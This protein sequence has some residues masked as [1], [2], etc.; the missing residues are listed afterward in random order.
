MLER[1]EVS[2]MWCR[3][4][5]AMELRLKR[6]C[7]SCQG[8]RAARMSWKSNPGGKVQTTSLSHL[9]ETSGDCAAPSPL[10]PR[11]LCRFTLHP[12]RCQHGS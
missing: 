12:P 2:L 9:Q 5:W 1:V 6:C 4:E 10:R 3:L 7:I 11:S 8:L